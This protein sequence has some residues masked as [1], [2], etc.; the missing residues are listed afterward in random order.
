MKRRYATT[1]RPLGSN[2]VVSRKPRR[3]RY[4]RRG[5]A[6]VLAMMFLVIFSSLAAAMAIVSQGNLQTADS[7]LKISRSLSAAETGMNFAIYRLNQVTPSV[8]TRKGEIDAATAS[9]LWASVAQALVDDFNDGSNP[10]P[11]LGGAACTYDAGT[12]QVVIPPIAVGPGAPAFRVTM[13][14]HPLTGEDYDAAYYQRPPYADMNPPV[15]SAAAL[16]ARWIRVEVT[17]SDGPVGSQI[18]RSI[19]MDFQLDKRIRFALLSRSRVMIGRNVMIEG[20]IGSRFLETNLDNGHP[21]QMESDFRGLHPD[22]D[23]NLDSLV[24]SLIGDA[25]NH[26]T[27]GD[28]RIN[29]NN[30]TELGSIDPALD[31]NGDG[32]IDG[33]DFFLDHFDTIGGDGKINLTELE[34][35][36]GTG[37][38]A[39]Q[40][41]QLLELI[42]TFG[43]PD[44]AGYNDGVIDEL[45]RYAKVRGEL[46][47]SADVTG[48]NAGAAGGAYQDYL[49]GEI[50]PD[51][52]QSPLTFQAAENNVHSFAPSDF[53]VATFKTKATGDLA[54]QT[55]A[56]VANNSGGDPSGAIYDNAGVSEAVPYGASHPYDYYDRPVYR[57]MTFTDVTIPKGT[58]ALFEDCTFVGVTFVETETTNTDPNFNYA[59]MQNASGVETHPDRSVT[60][61]GTEYQSSK[62]LANNLRFHN[63]TFDGGI[64]SDSPDEFTHTRNKIAFTGETRFKD[65]TK[66]AVEDP[67]NGSTLSTADRNLYRRSTILTPHYSIEMGTFVSPSN[68]NETIQLSGTIVAGVIDMR[69]QVKVDGTLITTFEPMSNTGPVLGETSPQ[70]NTTLGYFSSADGDLEAE[71][72]SNGVGVIQVRYDPT[73]PLPDGILGPVEVLPLMSTYFE[74]G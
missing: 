14:P 32:Y 70:F 8:T 48:W 3:P 61:A 71:L 31:V 28:N 55:A 58:N 5:V 66:S 36:L 25:T 51:F 19:S 41:A 53:D 46:Y 12:G 62:E 73:I 50:H 63:C 20:P 56:Q 39:V 26:D 60:I 59:G 69:G 65:M 9:T 64:V 6:A 30:P 29:I 1:R 54:A 22:L 37:V 27:D 13:T 45:D 4:R 10:E 35:G 47:V 43:N 15:S 7:S 18:T 17:A 21:I 23:D 38:D 40:A 34:T 11:H 24:G 74:G 42:D 68:S 2:R 72:P 33:Y 16:D 49:Q 67:D 44:R 52:Q 57:N